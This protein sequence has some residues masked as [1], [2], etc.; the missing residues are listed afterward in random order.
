[1]P[2]EYQAEKILDKIKEL[3]DAGQH[4]F[5]YQY[6]KSVLARTKVV[7]LDKA[8][9]LVDPN[10]ALMMRLEDL[11]PKMQSF[12]SPVPNEALVARVREALSEAQIAAEDAAE[13]FYK[14]SSK[15]ANGQILDL[16]GF[17]GVILDSSQSPVTSALLQIDAATSYGGIGYHIRVSQNK[18]I[19]ESVGL[20]EAAAEA[21]R[22]VL[23]SYFPEL[24]FSVR[25]RLD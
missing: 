4:N 3:H 7:A 16:C 1:V 5:G 9:E 18:I 11:Y 25:T 13:I 6:D 8:F 14:R 12:E 17:S 21:A 24:H 20:A 19:D 2:M 15:D 22:E 10:K 23:R